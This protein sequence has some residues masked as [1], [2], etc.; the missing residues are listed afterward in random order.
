MNNNPNRGESR[1]ETSV[2]KTLTT[3]TKR[4]T[5]GA[6]I[7]MNLALGAAEP[8]KVAAPGKVPPPKLDMTK[9][10]IFD[11][12]FGN[13]TNSPKLSRELSYN[14]IPLVIGGFLENG[15]VTGA[16]APS[17]EFINNCGPV[18]DQD[19][20]QLC[21]FGP[22]H[23]IE[24]RQGAREKF[25]TATL[26]FT[27]NQVVGSWT[28]GFV[29]RKD[30]TKIQ[31]PQVEVSITAIATDC[32]YAGTY[33]GKLNEIPVSGDCVLVA[34]NV[35]VGMIDPLHAMYQIVSDPYRVFV[36]VRAGKV[37]Q[38][39]AIANNGGGWTGG[40]THYNSTATPSSLFA[41][42]ATGLTLRVSDEG[43][44]GK[45]VTL[46]GQITVTP[47]A[48]GGGRAFLPT[49]IKM[50]GI[51]LSGAGK[52][53]V[54]AKDSKVS[55]A[56]NYPLAD[57]RVA[58]WMELIKKT[59]RGAQPVP[60]ELLAQ[61]YEESTRSDVQPAPGEVT[62]YM[63]RKWEGKDRS[64]IYAPWFDFDFV[65]NAVRYRYECF[66]LP[67]DNV[68]TMLGS[69]EAASPRASLSPIWDKVNTCNTTRHY[70]SLVRLTALDAE[71]KPLGKPQ[72]KSFKR[73][74]PLASEMVVTPDTTVLMDLAM[75]QPYYLT[76]YLQS[77][78]YLTEAVVAAKNGVKPMDFRRPS[79]HFLQPLMAEQESD[80]VRRDQYLRLLTTLNHEHRLKQ[81]GKGFFKAP[82]HYGAS[83]SVI[84]TES[85]R[86]FLNSLD[87]QPDAEI[88]DRLRLW[89]RYYTRWQ[90]PSGSFPVNP[91]YEGF[92]CYGDY[93]LTGTWFLEG[94]SSPVLPFM[95]RLRQHENSPTY[96]AAA[97]AIE[98]RAVEFFRNNTLRTGIIENMQPQTICNDGGHTFANQAEYAIYV[99]RHAPPAQRDAVMV[100]DLLR[101]IEDLF[102]TWYPIPLRD[103]SA[104]SIHMARSIYP[105]QAL[106]LLELYA[107]TGDPLLRFKSEALISS[108]L[109]RSDPW[110]GL[111]LIISNRIEIEGDDPMWIVR[112]VK[113]DRELRA[114]PPTPVA[115]RH[116][117]MTLDRLID[118]ADRVVLD[119]AVA[120]GQI[121]Q[122]LARTPTWDG[123]GINFWQPGRV[124]TRPGKAL[125]HSVD[126]S[127]L[128]LSP[129]GITGIVKLT[130]TPPQGTEIRNLTVEVNAKRKFQRAWQGSWKT[131][132][133]QGRV[134]GITLVD[135]ETKGAQ[136]IFVQVNEALMGGEAWQNWALAGAV[137]PA[138]GSATAPT[139][140]NANAGWTAEAS[141]LKDCAL[142]ADTFTMTMDS[143][144]TWHGVAERVMSKDKSSCRYVTTPESKQ[145]L[146]GYW[147]IPITRSKCKPPYASNVYLNFNGFNPRP[148]VGDISPED[149]FVY[150]TSWKNVTPGKY[151]LQ[152]NGKRLGNV[153]YGTCISTGPDGKASTRQ[154]L[155][156]VETIRTP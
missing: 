156:D 40:L 102:F 138:S 109:Q 23:E 50:D 93:A 125:F 88:L 27:G 106:G 90:S 28:L 118:G 7:T 110:N 14:G 3:W 83:W 96:R 18:S 47:N 4:V 57:P 97:R 105:I 139:F 144:V 84:P 35:P 136:Q 89:T 87:V 111:D 95:A 154:F 114:S 85:G 127:A 91:G 41:A 94:P 19:P 10:I 81:D 15:K 16:Y 155:G 148:E 99:L 123:P 56:R 45:S 62:R 73:R 68:G 63:H 108:Y 43:F 112:W 36:E 71:G 12:Q 42:D 32:G 60:A 31:S 119:L 147:E 44:D 150:D 116:I 75:R 38:A 130:L 103:N 33:T 48:A 101:R 141:G 29:S 46:G 126:T 20:Y 100:S 11:V 54:N 104:W 77:H 53:C 55:A 69:F 142:T 152:F 34:R 133:E 146:L 58:R 5:L 59:Y 153:L 1:K 39:L 72:E 2:K 98:E 65:P 66:D 21:P 30:P 67:N 26:Q 140:N 117:T 64:I 131:G 107:L 80:P 61:A 13:Y 137:L 149:K 113:R 52:M 79:G 145:A 25:S 8:A 115:E 74:L 22:R 151:R 92:S 124:H 17:L 122:A 6:I 24:F 128:K 82:L 120:D 78:L 86:N 129:T 9:P 132:K 135:P 49:T 121:T 51:V 37:M 134:E 143:E 70:T 76:E